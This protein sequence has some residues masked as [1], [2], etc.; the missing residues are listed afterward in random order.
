MILDFV[1]TLSL[2]LPNSVSDVGPLLT[3]IDFVE[4]VQ[5]VLTY[6]PAGVEN[7]LSGLQLPD[8][9]LTAYET[10]FLADTVFFGAFAIT[11]DFG[12]GLSRARIRSRPHAKL[13]LKSV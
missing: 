3:Q 8:G 11:K 10:D 13:P 12:Y 6:P 9:P 7:R 4:P 2:T 1:L 5:Q